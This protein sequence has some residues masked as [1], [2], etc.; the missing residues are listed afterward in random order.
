MSDILYTAKNGAPFFL[1]LFLLFDHPI[2]G[3]RLLS[4]KRKVI[5]QRPLKEN[6]LSGMAAFALLG[7]EILPSRWPRDD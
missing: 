4:R 1:T 5:W 6:T 7:V 2:P 3:L